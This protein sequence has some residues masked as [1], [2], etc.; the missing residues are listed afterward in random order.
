MGR[1]ILG[2]WLRAEVG[3]V[4]C[5]YPEEGMPLLATVPLRDCRRQFTLVLPQRGIAILHVSVL[6]AEAAAFP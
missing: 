5:G 3:P 4:Q 1:W 6:A 2:S